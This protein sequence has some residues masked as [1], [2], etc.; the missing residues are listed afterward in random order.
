[1]GHIWRLQHAC[2]SESTQPVW[3]RPAR[4]KCHLCRGA[5]AHGHLQTQTRSLMGRLFVGEGGSVLSG[6]RSASLAL[7]PPRSIR[8]L[9]KETRGFPCGVYLHPLAQIP[10][11]RL[12]RSEKGKV[13]AFPCSSPFKLQSRLW[14]CMRR[15]GARLHGEPSIA[16]LLESH[17]SICLGEQGSERGNA[18]VPGAGGWR[19]FPGR[20]T[21]EL[22]SCDLSLWVK[23]E[24]TRVR[25]NTCRRSVCS[26]PT[27]AQDESS[28][29][30]A[31]R[32]NLTLG[33]APKPPSNLEL[34]LSEPHTSAPHQRPDGGQAISESSENTRRRG[35]NG[36]VLTVGSRTANPRKKQP[37]KE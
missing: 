1:M 33:E 22:Y 2:H 36:A 27:S 29:R 25:H 18:G 32:G 16:C 10:V 4:R 8:R 13:Q 26:D 19:K 35:K 7:F 31:N 20:S 17:P 5:S 23:A 14:I 3:V 12:M 28:L 9:S 37:K 24:N 15:P 6:D 30:G 11:K 21:L 34:R